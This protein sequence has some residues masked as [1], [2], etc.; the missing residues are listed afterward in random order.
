MAC[1]NNKPTKNNII[2]KPIICLTI[3]YLSKNCRKPQEKYTY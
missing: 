3:I 2:K 1:S